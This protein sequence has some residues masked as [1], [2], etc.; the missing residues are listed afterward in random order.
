MW[1]VEVE[2]TAKSD[3]VNLVGHMVNFKSTMKRQNANM[4][5]GDDKRL[6]GYESF[7]QSKLG[8]DDTAGGRADANV[9]GKDHELDI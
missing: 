3:F 2:Y 8:I 1:F 5:V 7:Q 9:V 6:C 4:C